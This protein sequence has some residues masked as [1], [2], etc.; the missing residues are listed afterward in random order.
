MTIKDITTTSITGLS[1][2]SYIDKTTSPISTNTQTSPVLTISSETD[3]VYT[4]AGDSPASVPITVLS[5]DKP[6][7]TVL[8]DNLSNVVVWNPWIEKAKGMADF[9][10]K[11]GY[12]N[13]L[14]VEPGAVGTWQVLEPGDALE[15]AQTIVLG[16][17]TE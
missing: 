8:R 7:F 10:P 12:K 15:G 1:S 17:K 3:R 2:A 9:E 13:M 16:G 6:K 11:E 14:C 4:P 5:N